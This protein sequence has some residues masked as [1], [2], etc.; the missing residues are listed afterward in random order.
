M[1]GTCSKVLV[2]LVAALAFVAGAPAASPDVAAMNLQATDV[3]GAKVVNQ[4][5]VAVQGY[6][7]GHF[8][9]FVFSAPKAGT[10]LIGRE[11]ET[12]LANSS[13]TASAGVGSATK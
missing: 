1:A 12:A 11:S 9:S 4:H 2:V 10:R 5:S 8:R 3:P 7:A 6:V 13:A